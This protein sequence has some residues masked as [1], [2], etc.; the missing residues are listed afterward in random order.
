MGED[1]EEITDCCET[2]DLDKSN[3]EVVCKNCG[4]VIDKTFVLEERRAFDKSEILAR[5]QN[6][7]RN[8]EFGS[9]TCVGNKIDGKGQE[10]V[11]DKISLYNRLSK[12]QDSLIGSLERNFWEAKPKFR[13][14]CLGLNIPDYVKDTA[15]KIYKTCAT[16]KLTMGRSIDEFVVS[17]IY[18]S[19]RIHKIPRIFEEVIGISGI[20]QKR[21]IKCLRMIIT[22]VFPELNLIYEPISVE[23]L[24]FCF[25]EKLRLSVD[26]QLEARD[27]LKTAFNRKVITEGKNLVGYVCSALYI[28]TKQFGLNITQ[29]EISKIG[30]IT[31]VTLRSRNKELNAIIEDDDS[32]KELEEEK[33]RKLI[34]RKLK[35]EKDREKLERERM[36]QKRRQEELNIKLKKRLELERRILR[37]EDKAKVLN[38]LEGREFLCVSDCISLL[39][40]NYENAERLLEEMVQKDKILTEKSIVRSK[41]GRSVKVYCLNQTTP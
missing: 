11:G 40:S 9:R 18:A 16:K 4:M 34:A 22:E 23:Q 41:K 12:I 7:V 5:K 28:A 1:F 35:Q 21:A 38:F 25:G 33:Q 31:E 30:G 39:T 24:V 19:I 6:E 29:G 37:E 26:I 20:S 8:R 13:Q 3:G 17:A 32:H 2:P 27:L 15:W 10:L 36:E 14:M